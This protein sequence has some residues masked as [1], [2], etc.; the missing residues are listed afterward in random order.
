M[1]AQQYD[2]LIRAARASIDAGRYEAGRWQAQR[3]IQV[4]P[5]RMAARSLWAE[6]Q[7]RIDAWDPVRSRVPPRF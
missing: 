5:R 6:A 2:E 4:D 1:R 7:T 3:A